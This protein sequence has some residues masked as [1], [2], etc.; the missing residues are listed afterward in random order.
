MKRHGHLRTMVTD[1]LR[2][3]GV[4]KTDLDRSDDRET[5]RW[6][7]NRAKPAHLPLRRRERA[8]VRFRRMRTLQKRVSEHQ[9]VSVCQRQP[10]IERGE[11]DTGGTAEA[12]AVEKQATRVGLVNDAV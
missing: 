7:H 1:P 10:S 3:C 6:R 9:E 12:I 2:F 5:G 4:A 11:M 8:M